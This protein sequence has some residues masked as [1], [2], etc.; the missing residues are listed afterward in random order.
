MESALL[1]IPPTSKRTQ[2]SKVGPAAAGPVMKEPSR[3]ASSASNFRFP[4]F[5]APHQPQSLISSSIVSSSSSSSSSN[6]SR[7]SSSGGQSQ[8]QGI[9]NFSELRHLRSSAHSSPRPQD[10]AVSSTSAT[11]G[12]RRLPPASTSFQRAATRTPPLS[13]YQRYSA[14]LK[15][16]NKCPTPGCI[17][18]GHVTG[19]YSH[20]RSLSGCPRR[21]KVSSEL[22]ALH[23]TILKCPT[24]GCNG[25]GHVSTGRNSHRSLSGCPKA[26]ASKAA[27]RELKYQNG[28]LFRQKLHTAVIKY[29][30][31]SDCRTAALVATT[32]TPAD[33]APPTSSSSNSRVTASSGHGLRLA[34]DLSGKA[35]V[36]VKTEQHEGE[37]QGDSSLS[38]SS[39]SFFSAYESGRSA[40]QT[41]SS[42]AAAGHRQPVSD[43]A[44][45]ESAYGRDQELVRYGQMDDLRP[46]H[47]HHHLHHHQYTSVA[48]YDAP[49]P[50][51]G[52]GPSGT[53]GWS[54]DPGAFERYDGA[55]GYGG[56]KGPTGQAAP[57]YGAYAPLDDYSSLPGLQGNQ[58]GG[59][60]LMA[61]AAVPA[62]LKMELP[63]E[64]PRHVYHYHDT[65]A[66]VAC[67]GAQV[68]PAASLSVSAATNNTNTNPHSSGFSA[69]NLS[70]KV[71][72]PSEG[73]HLGSPS[74]SG[75]GE[76]SSA[77]TEPHASSPTD[78]GVS[79]SSSSSSSSTTENQPSRAGEPRASSSRA[80]PKP[81]T[82]PNHV[83]ANSPHTASPQG[84]TLDL[85]VNR[86]PHASGS[87]AQYST[88]HQAETAEPAA[89]TNVRSPPAEPVDFSGPTSAGA[90]RSGG[91]GFGFMGPPGAAAQ[92]GYS[93]ESTPDSAASHYLE[94]YRDQHSGYS[95]HPGY[96]MVEYANGY[97]GYGTNYQACPPFGASL[98]RYGVTVPTGY[99]PTGGACY[100]MP[101]PSHIPSSHDKL[102]KDGLTGL[103]RTDRQYHH[104]QHHANTQELKCPTPGCDGSGH[105]TGNYSS[106][107]SLSG[108]P[109]ATKPKNK[110]RDGQE[111]EPLRCPIP[112]CD[113]SGHST[114]KFLS[115]RSASGCPIANR[116]RIRVMDT[117]HGHGGQGGVESLSSHHPKLNAAASDQWSVGQD[118]PLKKTKYS[119]DHPMIVTSGYG[120]PYSTM[121]DILVSAERDASGNRS[122]SAN[123][124]SIATRSQD[125]HLVGSTLST[126][127]PT[128]DGP[129][130]NDGDGVCAGPVTGSGS[131]GED[132]LSLE[133]EISELQRE[134]ARVESQMLR[135][136]T[137]ISA[138]E[139]HL[140]NTDRESEANS[141]IRGNHVA[142]YYDHLRNNVIT[143]LENV[144]IPPIPAR[145]SSGLHLDGCCGPLLPDGSGQTRTPSG[146]EDSRQLTLGSTDKGQSSPAQPGP[147]PVPPTASAHQRGPP[148]PDEGTGGQFDNYLSKLQSLCSSQPAVDVDGLHLVTHQQ[149]AHPPAHLPHPNQQH[150]NQQHH[151]EGHVPPQPLPSIPLPPL[152]GVGPVD[153]NFGAPL[154]TPI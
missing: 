93:R 55:T 11:S 121:S 32:G 126:H 87:P 23:E 116:N 123:S 62:L 143:L 33:N 37:L 106:H 135:L 65:T 134:N 40:G 105:A 13:T 136:K 113:G 128:A 76:R 110:P 92:P 154:T 153:S 102:L 97:P 119:D 39:S 5:T 16:S 79:S 81:A 148:V 70:V 21:D 27:A 103:A 85:S 66:S 30:Q 141:D 112:G 10:T 71:A 46:H 57:V 4:S 109:R 69:I 47:H 72:T 14:G 28:L 61:P 82:S 36:I 117:A 1:R 52:Q 96:G 35:T 139:S 44:M 9:A 49:G 22:L 124:T 51:P 152:S 80:S 68:S 91:L 45:L 63:D 149:L 132:L 77:H 89:A 146:G 147:S 75:E 2:P 86:M 115:H 12:T 7:S 60:L 73:G 129:H 74:R 90:G 67:S 114:G 20:H 53:G 108:C 34:E 78:L 24:P 150:L 42:T 140:G 120:K 98:G 25:R 29:Q 56:Q 142:G 151:P 133:A 127:S 26:A 131:T 58:G 59:S 83:T 8:P 18:L 6:S 111:S 145:S 104:H 54:Y 43:P 31:L 107:R 94:G 101:P 64:Y 138:M 88:S 15:E 95:P 19:L 48:H 38:S 100:A 50:G 41:S 125:S 144:K 17:G 137:D 99:T 122:A 118:L 130:P 3:V 84:H